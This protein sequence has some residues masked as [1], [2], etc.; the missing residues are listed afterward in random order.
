[1]EPSMYD[2]DGNRKYMT[3]LECRRFLRAA[4]A[5]GSGPVFTFCLVLAR[6]GGRISEVL[7]LTPRHIDVE[8]RIILLRTLKQRKKRKNVM[9]RPIPVPAGVIRAL[10]SVHQIKKARKDS[11]RID[12]RIW[13]WCRTTGWTRVKE[14]R[15]TADST[16]IHAC[17]KGVRHGYAIEALV[18]GITD[19]MVMRLLGH[20]RIETTLVYTQ[21]VGAEARVIANRMWS[22]ALRIGLRW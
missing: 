9:Y 1:M 2:R 17:P 12:E 4:K 15:A 22:W 18:S 20:S 21:V 14:V 10:D 13:P 11:I 16:G 3:A 19:I 8:S 7:A 5:T 6:T